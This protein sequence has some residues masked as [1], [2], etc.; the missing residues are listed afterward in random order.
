M[1]KPANS[2]GEEVSDDSV[3]QLG[4][5]RPGQLPPEDLRVPS[6]LAGFRNVSFD[7]F[8]CARFLDEAFGRSSEPDSSDGQNL[9]VGDGI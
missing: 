4:I 2:S 6:M 7:A 9:C 5:A 1:R 3:R 8:E